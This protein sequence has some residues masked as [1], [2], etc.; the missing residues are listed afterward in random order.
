[1][2]LTMQH[3][4]SVRGLSKGSR[5]L[6]VRGV[7]AWFK[8]RGLDY[9]DFLRNGIDEEIILALDDAFANEIVR[10]AHGVE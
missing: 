10:Q 7:R 6:C 5:G 4:R 2:K 9:S 1:M 8:S 3:V